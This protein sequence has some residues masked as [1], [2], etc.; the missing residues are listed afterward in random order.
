MQIQNSQSM[1]QHL[2]S[3]GS[4]TLNKQGQLETQSAAGRLFQKS[5]DAFRSITSSGRAAIETRN[6]NLN[7]A[8]ASMLRR[9]TLVNPAQNE[10]FSP[11]TKTQRNALVMR[12]TVAQAVREFPP[13]TRAAA[14]NLGLDLLRLQGLPEQGNPA[15]TRGK[16]LEV[17]NK[18]L[19][20]EAVVNILRC[21]YEPADADLEPMLRE[22]SEDIPVGFLSQKDKNVKDGIFSSYYADIKRGSVEKL[23]GKK[24]NTES[25][26]TIAAELKSLFPDPKL[27]GFISMM[28]SQ[29]GL[30]FQLTQQ[31]EEAG[32]AKDNP[33]L[34]GGLIDMMEK[35]FATPT[36]HHRYSIRVEDGKARISVEIDRMLKPSL[37][38]VARNLGID[39]FTTPGNRV[40]EQFLGGGRYTIEMEVDLA[41]DMTGKEVPD[42]KLVSASRKPI[43]IPPSVA[44]RPKAIAR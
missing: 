21:D 27:S 31:F 43:T 11:M 12:F 36:P 1:T 18:I 44:A 25:N 14:Q 23:D 39:D 9:D 40:K 15:E 10:M 20:D 35:G 30:E 16:A 29:S 3:G 37:S 34:P 13:E 5:G 28:A 33:N 6:A 17:M 38:E 41:Q 2:E 42:F 22:I 24:P 7:T 8:M 32:R 19:G 4:L 26:E